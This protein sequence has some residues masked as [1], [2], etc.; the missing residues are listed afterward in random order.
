[1]RSFVSLIDTTREDT[2]RN[3]NFIKQLQILSRKEMRKGIELQDKKKKRQ[4]KDYIVTER[5]EAHKVEYFPMN[6][7]AVQDKV[8][9]EN[10]IA[11]GMR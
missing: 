6:A 11:F 4:K 1:M 5:L 10:T 9:A 2:M 7:L 3:E 8:H